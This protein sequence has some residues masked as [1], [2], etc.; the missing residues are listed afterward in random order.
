MP[1]EFEFQQLV[2]DLKRYRNPKVPPVR[3]IIKEASFDPELG[4][5]VT[6]WGYLY[7]EK[8]LPY[9]EAAF[10]VGSIKKTFI[11]FVHIVS[12]K[13]TAFFLWPFLFT[14]I[15][16]AAIKRFIYY[17]T[18]ASHY[19]LDRYILTDENFSISAREI[20]RAG[21]ALAPKYKNPDP[22]K[23]DHSYERIIDF[24][25]MVWEYDDAYR[26]RFQDFF[27]LFDKDLFLVDPSKELA[28]LRPIIISREMLQP[29]KTKVFFFLFSFLLRYKFIKDVVT[30]FINKL[31]VDKLR[32]DKADK[33][34]ML[35]HGTY[36]F[37]GLSNE[38]RY[39][40]RKRIHVENGLKPF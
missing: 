11:T 28:R 16:K 26:Y 3:R 6:Y 9:P 36:K 14:P 39:L 38:E 24:I 32:P 29:G 7:P 21:Y 12:T 34:W 15:L 30:E 4:A 27:G 5:Q 37:M 40:E 22:I 23:N 8:L 31:D 18:S 20:R 35:F 25:S 33:Y 19:M 10:A 13:W 17:F 2:P 1:D